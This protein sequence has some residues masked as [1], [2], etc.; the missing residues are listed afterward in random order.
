M[1]W[2]PSG[3]SGLRTQQYVQALDAAREKPSNDYD[4]SRRPRPRWLP[5]TLVALILLI[6]AFVLVFHFILPVIP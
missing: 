1:M 4:P 3:Q 6:L 5:P 2:P